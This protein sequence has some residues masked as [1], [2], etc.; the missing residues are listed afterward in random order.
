MNAGIFTNQIYK[1]SQDLLPLELK[2]RSIL[3]ML[4]NK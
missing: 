2:R 1:N 3:T 4:K